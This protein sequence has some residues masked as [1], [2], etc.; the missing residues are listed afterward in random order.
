MQDVDDTDEDIGS[1]A[2]KFLHCYDLSRICLISRVLGLMCDGQCKEMQNYLRT[3]GSN[4]KSVNM[5]EEIASFVYEFTKKQV[6]N[7]ETITLFNHLVE[8]LTKFCIGNRKNREVAFNG[9]VISAIN[10]VLHIDITKIMNK[11]TG[12]FSWLGLGSDR[13]ESTI[14]YVTLRKMALEMKAAVVLLLDALLE[15]IGS[16]SSSLSHQIADGLDIASLHWSM[17]DFFILKS[18][19]DLIRLEFD[20]NA[21]RALFNAYKIIQQLADNGFASIETLSN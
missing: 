11:E 9:N 4:V 12:M 3:Q 17:L 21:S 16:K 20:D 18:D 6:F 1:K 5:V 2:D 14:D 8:A 10:Y 19:P 7:I 15:E 13:E